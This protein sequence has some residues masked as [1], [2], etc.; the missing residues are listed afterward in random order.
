MPRLTI[1][2]RLELNSIPEPNSGCILW[3]GS[4]LWN[5][6]GQFKT[7]TANTAPRASWEEANGRPVPD[8]LH[9]MHKCDNRACINPAHLKIGTRQDNMDDMKAKGRQRHGIAHKAAKLTPDQVRAIRVDTRSSR[10]ISED[11]PVS[12]DNVRS[13]KTGRC[14]NHVK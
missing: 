10:L 8:G 12:A 9:V 11:Y 5:G 6:Y 14:W 2:E 13:I 4:Y 3:T 1:A 7:D